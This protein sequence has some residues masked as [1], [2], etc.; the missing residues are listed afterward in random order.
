MVATEDG[1]VLQGMVVYQAVDSLLLQTGPDKT[2][3][4]PADKIVRQQRSRVS[5]MPTGLLDK[6]ADQEI[7][8]LFAYLQS[9][10]K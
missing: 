1:D 6:L 3:R 4:V 5:L 9:L 8:D 2:V 7:A 10:N